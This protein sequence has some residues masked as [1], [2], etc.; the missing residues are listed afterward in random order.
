SFALMDRIVVGRYQ[1]PEEH[2]PDL[3]APILDAIRAALAHNPSE[4]PAS[5]EA[6]AAMLPVL[7]PD[8]HTADPEP[9]ER[10]GSVPAVTQADTLMLGE[11]RTDVGT[12]SARGGVFETRSGEAPIART[13]HWPDMDV[14]V[15]RA[16]ELETL[17]SEYAAAARGD[18]RLVVVVGDAGI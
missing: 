12:A 1:P 16:A 17:K 7:L 8:A 13:G 18:G 10:S 9:V 2:V 14:F 11:A 3:P 5:P 4:R 15:G 6:L